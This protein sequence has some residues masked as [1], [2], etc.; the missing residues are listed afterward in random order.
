MRKFRLEEGV[1]RNGRKERIKKK[2]NVVE[3]GK[4]LNSTMKLCKGREQIWGDSER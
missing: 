3:M 2:V 4:R 1:E